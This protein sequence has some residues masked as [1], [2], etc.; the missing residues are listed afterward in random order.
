MYMYIVHVQF[1]DVGYAITLKILA[2]R[3]MPVDVQTYC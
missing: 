2:V 1:M 3:N